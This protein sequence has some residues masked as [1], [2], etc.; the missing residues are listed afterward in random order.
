MKRRRNAENS[1]SLLE[2]QCY[3]A[4]TMNKVM[5]AERSRKLGQ[6]VPGKDLVI[7]PYWGRYLR[8]YQAQKNFINT[9]Y[10]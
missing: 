9:A 2:D 10:Q 7:L 3:C 1:I 4:L 8:L 5:H 6:Q